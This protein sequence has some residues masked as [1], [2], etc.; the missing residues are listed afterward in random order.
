MELSGSHTYRAAIDQVEAMLADPEVTKAR[1]ESMGHRDVRV[2]EVVSGDG[3]LRVRA[4][5]VVDVQLPGFAKAVLKPT[6]TMLQTD[7]WSRNKDGSW[8]GTFDVEVKGAPVHISG[9]MKL[10]P[11]GDECVHDVAVKVEVHVPFVGGRIASWAANGDVRRSI[12][13]EAAFNSEWLAGH[14]PA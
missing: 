9:T 6:N 13:A 3:T 5:R 1:Y 11:S 14:S 7:E 8:S 12:E 4:S 10:T 2:L